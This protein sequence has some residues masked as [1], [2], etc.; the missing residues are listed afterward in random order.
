MSKK[1]VGCGCLIALILPFVLL[2]GLFAVPVAV[3]NIACA[4]YAKRAERAIILPDGAVILDVQH[5]CGNTSGTGDHTEMV[6]ALLIESD[7][8][9]DAK[10]LSAQLGMEFSAMPYSSWEYDS[11]EYDTPWLKWIGIEFDVQTATDDYYVVVALKSA[12]MSW[13]D[14]R[15][16]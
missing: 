5:A 1:A 7:V 15:G 4:A 12:P 6:A 2:F 13:L 3:D 14:I 8:P 16:S 9:L 11:W 10:P